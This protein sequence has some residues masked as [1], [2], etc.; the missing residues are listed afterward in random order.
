MSLAPTLEWQP[1]NCVSEKSSGISLP[2]K[3][4]ADK[5]DCY[6]KESDPT[7]AQPHTPGAKL[8][9]GKAK[10]MQGVIQYFPRALKAVSGVSEAGAEKYTWNGWESVPDGINRYSNAMGRHL[11]AAVTEGLY[12]KDTGCLHAAQVAWNAMAVLE[13]TLRRLERSTHEAA[14][15]KDESV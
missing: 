5:S 13:L 14:T 1:G 4:Y 6:T 9:S 8:D 10:I 12:D 2:V 11:L 3:S 7:G 15:E